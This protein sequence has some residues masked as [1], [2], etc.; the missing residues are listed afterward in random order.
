MAD[1]YFKPLGLTQSDKY[2]YISSW[3][4]P[5][6]SDYYFSLESDFIDSVDMGSDM[7]YLYVKREVSGKMAYTT[8]T[9]TKSFF[10]NEL[11]N[12]FKNLDWLVNNQ[13]QKLIAQ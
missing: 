3:Q 6:R 4:H 9:L 5:E 12:H 2:I 7:V 10:E 1:S 13:F 8:Y 11:T